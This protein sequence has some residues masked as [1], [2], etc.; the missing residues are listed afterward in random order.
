[1]EKEAE[2]AEEES[3]AEIDQMSEIHLY[4]LIDFVGAFTWRMT[5]DYSHGRIPE[6]DWPGIQKDINR[7]RERQTRAAKTLSKFGVKVSDDG[8]PTDEYWAWYKWWS[9]WHKDELSA[10]EWDALDRKLTA[11][12]DVSAFRPKGDWRDTLKEKA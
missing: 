6:N 3:L 2:K 11:H 8:K 1:M 5:H 9:H 7:L 10:E 12:E 4:F